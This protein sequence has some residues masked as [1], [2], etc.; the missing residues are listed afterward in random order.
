MNKYY[1]W[2]ARHDDNMEALSVYVAM[3]MEEVENAL[4]AVQLGN[5]LA[6]AYLEQKQGQPRAKCGK[7]R[8]WDDEKER[9][10][11]RRT[12]YVQFE[13][14]NESIINN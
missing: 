8:P 4:A 10:I 12:Q 11:K 2:E 7:K 14:V 6:S 5:R 9:R 13:K 3:H 1:L